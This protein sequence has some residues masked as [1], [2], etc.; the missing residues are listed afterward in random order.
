MG[1][2]FVV[3]VSC[4]NPA[5]CGRVDTHG[6]PKKPLCNSLKVKPGLHRKG[7][8]AG[9]AK[10]VKF[11]QRYLHCAQNQPK[12]GCILLAAKLEGTKS[13]ENNGPDTG[14]EDAEFDA[15]LGQ[16]VHCCYKE[17]HLIGACLQF[18]KFSPLSAWHEVWQH[19]DKHS[20]RGA[21]SSTFKSKTQEA[22][23][24][25]TTGIGLGF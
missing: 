8:N 1:F 23:G 20:A 21:G 4:Q 19:A 24:G 5:I 15:Y 9:N 22:K 6:D 7:E 14:H 3:S 12:R 11:L 16:S 13:L 2:P 18:E 17:K 25:K 10:A